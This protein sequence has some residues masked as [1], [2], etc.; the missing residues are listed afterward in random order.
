MNPITYL[1]E[2]ISE[3]RLVRWPT[4]SETTRLTG[5]V[6]A[7]SIFVAI[8]IGALDYSFTHLLSFIIK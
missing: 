3:L 4:W 5:I 8:Y 1:K 6:I 2:T 7:L